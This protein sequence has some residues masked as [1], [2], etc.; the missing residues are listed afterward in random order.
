MS[1][2]TTP[3]DAVVEYIT[4][5]KD[6]NYG[7]YCGVKFSTDQGDIWKNYG[8]D[9]DELGSLMKG[10][11]VR[12]VPVEKDGK[13]SHQIIIPGAPPTATAPASKPV[14][15]TIQGDKR[16]MASRADE[17]AKHFRHCWDLVSRELADEVPAYEKPSIAMELFK[18]SLD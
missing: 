1:R 11:Q 9:S 13:I 15:A 2:I 18:R 10:S 7:P 3:I 12:L 16:S 6:G 8:V 4:P 5:P 14:T 17:L